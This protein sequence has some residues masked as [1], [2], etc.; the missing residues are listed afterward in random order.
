M[1]NSKK[2]KILHV[3][4]QRP[5]STGS[6]MYIQAMIKEATD[7]GHDNYL[8]AGVH[9]ANCNETNQCESMFVKFYNSDVSYH[10]PGMSDIMPYESSKFCNLSEDN[11]F[12]Y[13]EAFSRTL[14]EAVHKF[15]PDIIH[16]HHLWLVSAIARQLFPKIP[17]V[18]TCH[19]TDLRQFQN[20]PHL[21]EKVLKGCRKIDVIMA[22]ST[23][24]RNEIINLYNM[25]QKKI[26]ITGVGYNDSLF[27]QETK[28]DP[29]PVQLIYAGKLSNA[30]GVPWLL[31]GLKGIEGVD[32]KLNLVGSG[33]GNEKENCLTLAEKIGKKVI[34]HGSLPQNKLAKI[35][36]QSHVLIL[37]SFYEGLPLVILEGLASGCRIVCT[38]LPGVREIL[39]NLNLLADNYISRIA[40]PRLHF[41]DQPHQEDTKAFE[42]DLK[43][44]LKAQISAATRSPQVDLS[45]IADKISPFTWSGLFKKVNKAYLLSQRTN[46]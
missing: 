40:L 5:D 7:A 45:I 29:N 34:V 26:I 3:L 22:L 4:S 31:R 8:V 46:T 17:M 27:Y 28:P 14:I 6:G 15:Q 43:H 32:W 35:M 36:R 39:S 25:D 23:D 44:A 37:P 11:L 21:Q 41:I 42:L 9:A 18:T 12:E 1:S 19:G 38:D 20:C 2:L 13:E 16:S 30:K 33:T 24:Q 10:I